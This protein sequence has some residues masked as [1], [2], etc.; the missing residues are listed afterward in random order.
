MFQLLI[1]VVSA[2]KMTTLQTRNIQTTITVIEVL[3][4]MILIPI[5]WNNRSHKFSTEVQDFHL[6][7]YFLASNLCGIFA[8]KEK[9]KHKFSL[10]EFLCKCQIFHK[11]EHEYT[12]VWQKWTPEISCWKKYLAWTLQPKETKWARH[13]TETKARTKILRVR[14]AINLIFTEPASTAYP[15]KELSPCCI[16][17]HYC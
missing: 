2:A 1:W 12:M 17:H 11:L 16:L 7:G 14:E 9:Q 5:P 3:S 15:L 8:A 13:N 6:E 10:C 4:S